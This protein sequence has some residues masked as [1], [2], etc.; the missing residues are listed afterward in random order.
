MFALFA[1]RSLCVSSC[2]VPR[3]IHRQRVGRIR[4]SLQ[5]SLPPPLRAQGYGYFFVDLEMPVALRS[6]VEEA[7]LPTVLFRRSRGLMDRLSAQRA[8][9]G[10]LE[11]QLRV[12]FSEG[13]ESALSPAVM[14]VSIEAC[15]DAD[16][17]L[18]VFDELS[19]RGPGRWGDDPLLSQLLLLLLLHRPAQGCCHQR[20]PR[21]P[22][23]QCICSLFGNAG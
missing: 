16:T 15:E 14:S 2:A 1:S 19:W 13:S 20:L 11:A 9:E 4:L 7:D 18:S 17:L 8:A 3:H 23:Q 21:L 10:A 12:S 5:P 6:P 22:P